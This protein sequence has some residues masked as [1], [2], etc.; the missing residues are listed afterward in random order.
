MH[1]ICAGT[2]GHISLE[3]SLLA[4]ALAS[5]IVNV[6]PAAAFKPVRQRRSPHGG[7]PVERCRT[8]V[9][10]ASSL[11]S[12]QLWAGADE[13]LDGIGLGC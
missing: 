8:L 12:P 13:N 5:Q 6:Q 1:I 7:L 4:G 9:G 10:E 3:D 2:D 11:V